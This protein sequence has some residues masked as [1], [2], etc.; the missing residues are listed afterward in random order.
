MEWVVGWV[1]VVG[2]VMGNALWRWRQNWMNKVLSNEVGLQRWERWE[3]FVIQ[4]GEA[5]TCMLCLLE[6]WVGA[7]LE[8]LSWEWPSKHWILGRASRYHQVLITI[9]KEK[10][11]DSWTSQEGV[12]GPEH[13]KSELPDDDKTSSLT[14][15]TLA[16][17]SGPE[18][19]LLLVLWAEIRAD[20]FNTGPSFS[21][22]IQTNN[23]FHFYRAVF[24]N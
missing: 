12:G 8:P 14:F 10:K 20:L 23:S 24:V 2:W 5:G 19:G 3:E 13:S 22:C 21:V 7:L 18:Q 6:P 1:V 16:I 17:G 9:S 11:Q 15:K 4:D